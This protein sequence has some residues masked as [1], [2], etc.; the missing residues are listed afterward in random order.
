MAAFVDGSF[1]AAKLE[2][3]AGEV[4]G[5]P[6]VRKEQYERV[7]LDRQLDQRLAQ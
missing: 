6:I 1:A 3:A 7:L 5:W 4:A 2:A